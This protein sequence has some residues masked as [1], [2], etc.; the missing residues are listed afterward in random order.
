MAARPP[1]FKRGQRRLL[2][3]L[4]QLGDAIRA[5][6]LRVSWPLR[7]LPTSGGFLLGLD[8]RFAG[9]RFAQIAS[10]PFTDHSYQ[11]V[12][13]RRSGHAWINTGTFKHAW[14]MNDNQLIGGTPYVEILS[15]V[16]SR[17]LLFQLD[18]C[19]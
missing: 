9:R 1:N 19:P 11:V 14:E 15:D 3:P 6:A 5:A 16:R 10:G 4:N 7:L 12:I 13:V 2:A 8:A 18:P 17:D